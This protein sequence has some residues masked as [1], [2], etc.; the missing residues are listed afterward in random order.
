MQPFGDS[1]FKI[2][3]HTITNISL[4]N[5]NSLISSKS[6]CLHLHNCPKKYVYTLIQ[7]LSRVYTLQLVTS[8]EE[9]CRFPPTF[10]MKKSN[11]HK[12]SLNLDFSDCIC[13]LS[14]FFFLA[15]LLKYGPCTSRKFVRNPKSWTLFK[16]CGIRICI[17]NIFNK[18]S[19]R[20]SSCELVV[21]TEVLIWF[22]SVFWQDHTV[23]G[24][25]SLTISLFLSLL[26]AHACQDW[27]L[28]V[29]QV[30]INVGTPKDQPSACLHSLSLLCPCELIYP[31]AFKY[32]FIVM[33][34]KSF[35][36][37]LTCLWSPNLPFQLLREYVF[38]D[39]QPA[40]LTQQIKAQIDIFP[41]IFLLCQ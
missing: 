10:S 18:I 19:R 14:Y 6:Q 8:L 30:S 3:H 35:S 17:F 2:N 1:H 37:I 41:F 40:S 5:N 29:T 36:L 34:H 13:M 7:D 23:G 15:L 33:I 16:D 38:L 20:F 39:V 31:R 28:C 22:D 11:C 32:Y 9:I 21:R 27:C 12:V 24:G 26:T 25:S 4:I